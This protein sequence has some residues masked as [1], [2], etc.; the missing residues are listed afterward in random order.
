MR[1]RVLLQ[2][3]LG[4]AAVSAREVPATIRSFYNS[5]GA[6][7]SCCNKLATGFYASDDGPDTFSYCGDHLSDY[8]VVYIQGVGGALA[9]MDVDCDGAQRAGSDDGRCNSSTDTQGETAFRSTV[10]GYGR[11]IADLDPFVHPY[12]VFGNEG[13]KP[14]WKTFDPRAYGVEPLS[15]VAVVCGDQLLYAIWGDTNGD[16]GAKPMVGEASIAL[17]T[18]C[19]GSSMSGNN[20][21]DATDVLYLAFA[22]SEAVPG[23]DGAAWDVGSFEEFEASIAAL[24]D[25]LVQRV[26]GRAVSVSAAR[27]RVSS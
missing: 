2:A 6:A 10:A 9:D 18:A 1:N 21:H 8:N 24:G 15:V 19:F 3:L 4:A 7:G 22:G 27:S 5:L 13:S 17:A 25:R 14:G 11:G 20:G 12:V 23:A 16:D 26:G